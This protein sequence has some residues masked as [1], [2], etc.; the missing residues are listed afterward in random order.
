MG[1]TTG[2]M[3]VAIL[4]DGESV[5]SIKPVAPTS[6]EL[7]VNPEAAESFGLTLPDALVEQGTVVETA[8]A[9]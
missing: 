5:S 6:T 3:A 7:L 4:R 9:S 2:E 1:R 8:K